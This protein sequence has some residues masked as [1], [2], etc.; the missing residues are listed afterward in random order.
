M[1]AI[2]TAAFLGASM[3]AFAATSASAEVVCNSDGDCWHVKERRVYE[4]GL[5]LRVYPNDWKWKDHDHEH[6]RWREHEGHGYWR[7]GIWIDL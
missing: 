3:L 4:P 7:N 1:K 2:S 6:Y 5:H